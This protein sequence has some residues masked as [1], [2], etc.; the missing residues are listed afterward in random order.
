M[1][2]C[3]LLT[4]LI[5]SSLESI[6][7]ADD[8]LTKNGWPASATRIEIESTK[9]KKS[10]PAIVIAAKAKK[11][12]PLL[13]ALHTWSGG[14]SQGGGEIVYAQWC[15]QNDWHLIHPHFRGPNN[16]PEA[17]GSEYVVQDILDAVQQMKLKHNVDP[18]RIYLVGVSGGGYASLLM[19]GRAPE[20]WAG[21]SAWC[22]ISDIEKWWRFHAIKNGQYKPGRY[23]KNIESA[24]GGRPD[25]S[26]ELQLEC[27]S[28]SP[29]HYLANSRKVNLDINHGIQDGR[30][31]SVPFTH[32]IEAFNR[33]AL[34]ADQISITQT[35]NYYSALKL[36]NGLRPA[37]PDNLY[38]NKKVLFRRISKNARLT[39]FDGG[40]EIIHVA[41]LN[42]LAQQV[43]GKSAKWIVKDAVQ[44]RSQLSTK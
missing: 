10:Q 19:A 41:A 28:R 14:F 6:S 2:T 21:V 5:L 12:R 43:R 8:E 25:A 16:T 37:T 13:V 20:V 44:L 15:I 22:S 27:V 42:W 40:H 33:V 23:A 31:G 32:S 39:I 4:C 7:L 1:R 24:L 18:D 35:E 30:K 17:M 3:T 36:P 34:P 9:D 26:S 29:N 38:D 11:P